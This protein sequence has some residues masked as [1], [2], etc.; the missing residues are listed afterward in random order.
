MLA[1]EPTFSKPLLVN[2]Y[3]S[4]YSPKSTIP[5]IVKGYLT[6]KRQALS[7]ACKKWVLSNTLICSTASVD[8]A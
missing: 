6:N 1:I 7:T 3:E 8:I 4:K 5:Y 2:P